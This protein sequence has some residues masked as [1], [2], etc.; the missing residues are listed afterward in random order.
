MD[1]TSIQ[2]AFNG[3]APRYDQTRR[4][5]IPCFDELYSTVLALIPY[6][7]QDR[8]RVLDLGAGTGLLSMF[9]SEHFPNAHVTLM[10]I[11]EAMLAKAR[12][13][14]SAT[15]G[16]FDFITADYSE[17]LTGEFDVVVS[18]LSIHH[19]SD[20]LKSRLFHRIHAILPTGGMFINADQV[21][22]ASPKVEK[23]YRENWIAQVRKNAVTTADLNAALERM[24]EDK[25]ATVTAQL[26]WLTD[27]GFAN[28]NCWYKNYS[29]AVYSGTK[30][31]TYKEQ[32]RT[33][34]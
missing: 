12:E 23:I 22:G 10:D 33:P 14:F 28:V 21:L 20:A 2:T 11:S 3:A 26:Q 1:T 9:I 4:Q 25:M 15:L 34:H 30:E 32:I 7:R 17:E 27:A 18:A 31:L 29:F 13:R 5:L 16:R 24:K 8:F 6:S 19:L